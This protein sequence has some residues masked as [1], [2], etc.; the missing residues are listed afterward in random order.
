M[1]LPSTTLLVKDGGLGI[2]GADISGVQVKVG[3]SSKGPLN[4]IK[5][6]TDADTLVDTFGYGKA[7]EAAAHSLSVAG[8]PVYFCRVTGSV[9][10]TMGAVTPT[11]IS[12]STGTVVDD[13]STPYDDFDVIV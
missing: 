11:R 9:A 3:T 2:A 4:T 12:T 7:V 8:G 13:T 1:T 6:F 10:G 5:G